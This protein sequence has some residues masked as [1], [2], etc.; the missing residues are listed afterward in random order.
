MNSVIYLLIFQG[1][2]GGYDV[3]WNHEWKEKLPTKPTA[4]L[5]Q[6]IHGIREL[7]YA[8]VFIG[9][10]WREWNGIWAWVLLSVIVIEVILT[11][12]DFVIE[13]KTRVLSPNERIAH[14]ILSMTG[15]AYVA[16]LIPVLLDWSYFPSELISIEYGL[17]SW[18]LTIFGIGVFAWGIRDINRGLALSR[19]K[20]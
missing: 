4:A 15:G 14:L 1:M 12:W 2:L 10:A 16:L 19:R 8:V 20:I 9:L 11:A 18:V 7:F 17:R 5:E 13:D 6:K 3:L